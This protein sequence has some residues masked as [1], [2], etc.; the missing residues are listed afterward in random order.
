MDTNLFFI[1][2]VVNSQNF[3]DIPANISK[4]SGWFYG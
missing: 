4:K 1:I 3:L 2:T